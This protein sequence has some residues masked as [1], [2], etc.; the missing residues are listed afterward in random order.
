MRQRHF[1]TSMTVALYALTG[2]ATEGPS[3]TVDAASVDAATVDA[4]ASGCPGPSPALT[5]CYV[6]FMFAECGGDGPARL[7]CR[8]YECLW[9]T[10][11]C[12]A[13]GFVASPCPAEDICCLGE[14][15]FNEPGQPSTLFLQFYA[16]GTTPWDRALSVNVTAELDASVSGTTSSLTCT[17]PDLGLGGNSPCTGASADVTTVVKPGTLVM[18]GNSGAGIAGW[19]PWIEFLRDDESATLTARFCAYAFR[20]TLDDVCPSRDLPVCASAGSVRLNRWPAGSADL[21][22][23]VV[24]VD[25]TFENGLVIQ[26]TLTSPS[27]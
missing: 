1:L 3:P 16:F 27:P 11:G 17:G 21:S 12:I 22:G 15:P 26:G 25:A 23:L 19:Y 14:W 10:G 20:D 4:P 2:C 24:S 6:G 13:D 8:E 18:A 5:S 9:F 7:A